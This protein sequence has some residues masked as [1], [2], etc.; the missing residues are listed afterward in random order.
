[1]SRAADTYNL[2]YFVASDWIEGFQ[3]RIAVRQRIESGKLVRLCVGFQVLRGNRWAEIVRYDDSH[4]GFHRHSPGIPPNPRRREPIAVAEGT[5][6][7]YALDDLRA[8]GTRYLREAQAGFEILEDA[9]DDESPSD[10]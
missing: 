4:G 1:M 10:A 8:N 6:V 7:R 5:E 2:E 9:D 3:I